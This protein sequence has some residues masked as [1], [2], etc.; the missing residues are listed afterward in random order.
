MTRGRCG[1]AQLVT[2]TLTLFECVMAVGAAA[3]SSSSNDLSAAAASPLR[4]RQLQT[5]DGSDGAVAIGVGE[6]FS[7]ALTQGAELAC[8]GKS[9][10]GRLGDG[11]IGSS[12]TYKPDAQTVDAD[13]L[14]VATFRATDQG[15]I[16]ATTGGYAYFWPSCGAQT[17]GCEDNDDHGV[18]LQGNLIS[19]G[20]AFQVCHGDQNAGH[21]AWMCVLGPRERKRG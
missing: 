8:W 18:M 2:M 5:N 4:T 21:T 6:S 9:M 7:C 19:S 15:G 16:A 12:S 13:G 10:N 17:S 11:T 14:S 1:A 3:S 20:F